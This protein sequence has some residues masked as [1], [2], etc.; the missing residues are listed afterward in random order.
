MRIRILENK[1]WLLNLTRSFN[2]NCILNSISPL[3]R[4]IIE[5]K[6][7]HEINISLLLWSNILDK[8]F[9]NFLTILFHFTNYIYFVIYSIINFILLI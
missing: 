9:K 3:I 2:Y 7:H 6:L 5:Y 8:F 4:I 1:I